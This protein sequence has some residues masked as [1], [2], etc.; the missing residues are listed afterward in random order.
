MSVMKSC[1]NVVEI[2]V[3][4]WEHSS[5]GLGVVQASEHYCE[6]L[7]CVV[8]VDVVFSVNEGR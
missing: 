7:I 2:S 5:L 4:C 3:G 1:V 6:C 8:T